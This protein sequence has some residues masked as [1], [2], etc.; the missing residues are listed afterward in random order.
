MGRHRGK[1]FLA[2]GTAYTKTVAGGSTMNLRDE[3]T[4]EVAG[5]E[6]QRG[7]VCGLILKAEAEEWGGHELYG[8]R[9]WS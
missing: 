9:G 4:G 3:Q 6:M 1:P 5:C 2:E 8:G 7:R